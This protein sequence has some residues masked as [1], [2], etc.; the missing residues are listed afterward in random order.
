MV[1]HVCEGEGRFLAGI[2]IV[3]ARVKWMEEEEESKRRRREEEE[4]D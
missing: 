3:I 2:S 4:G 1:A